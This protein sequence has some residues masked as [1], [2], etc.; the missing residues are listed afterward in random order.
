VL[1]LTQRERFRAL[2]IVRSGETIHNLSEALGCVFGDEAPPS[3]TFVHYEEAL[4][5]ALYKVGSSQV[6]ACADPSLASL[7]ESVWGIVCLASSS[8]L[9]TSWN[10]SHLMDL[11]RRGKDFHESIQRILNTQTDSSDLGGDDHGASGKES[12]RHALIRRDTS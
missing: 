5:T 3:T 10:I 2:M 6:L 9:L 7:Q 1:G 8:L 12:R 4:E 11:L